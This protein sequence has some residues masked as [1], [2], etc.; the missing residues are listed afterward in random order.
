MFLSYDASRI[1]GFSGF[2]KLAMP[3]YRDRLQMIKDCNFKVN[4]NGE[5]ESGFENLDGLTK[6]IDFAAKSVKEMEIVHV[7]SGTLAKSFDELE[8]NPIFDTLISDI[9][10]FYMNA[11][12][13]GNS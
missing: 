7:A 5:M 3:K 12:K 2:A 9:A 8:Y 4:Q 10:G 1:D 11:G 13:V 6:M